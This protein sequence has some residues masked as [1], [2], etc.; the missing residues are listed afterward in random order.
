MLAPL[1]RTHCVIDSSLVSKATAGLLHGSEGRGE[2]EET[3][4]QK[5]PEYFVQ[6][7]SQQRNEEV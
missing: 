3:L 5:I 2:R 4:E 6:Y 1:A 7:N